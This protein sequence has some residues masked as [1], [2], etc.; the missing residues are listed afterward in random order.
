[1]SA[2]YPDTYTLLCDLDFYCLFWFRINKTVAEL[3]K[4]INEKNRDDV[5]KV[6]E[7]NIGLLLRAIRSKFI[8]SKIYED[9]LSLKGY[10]KDEN[11]LKNRNTKKYLEERDQLIL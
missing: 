7:S 5:K 4:L 11:Y 10:Y 9:F 2:G 3:L 1:M 8:N 6:D